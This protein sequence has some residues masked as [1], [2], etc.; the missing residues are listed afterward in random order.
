MAENA[1]A[2][3]FFEAVGF[4]R[5]GDPA[6]APGFRT[7]EGGRMHVQLMVQTFLVTPR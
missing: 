6:H 5:H 3:A 4:R 1:G 2:I 7:R